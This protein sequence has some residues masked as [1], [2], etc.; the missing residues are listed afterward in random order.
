MSWDGEWGVCYT[1]Y[2]YYG[3]GL[4]AFVF[5]IK[6][7]RKMAKIQITESSGGGG[8]FPSG[9]SGF[10]WLHGQN[11]DSAPINSWG[12]DLNQTG[13]DHTETFNYGA[14][15]NNAASGV[16]SS[17]ANFTGSLNNSKAE[18]SFQYPGYSYTTSYPRFMS[19]NWWKQ[20]GNYVT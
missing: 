14:G 1:P 18:Y 15:S 4:S 13:H 6:N 16:Q 9:R 17:V 12:I 20:E 11:T 10:K 7:P 3:G 2:Y 5:S 19:V 8:L